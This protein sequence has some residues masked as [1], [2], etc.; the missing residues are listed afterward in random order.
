MTRS[1]TTATP[2]LSGSPEPAGGVSCPACGWLLYRKRLDRTPPLCPE[3]DHPPRLSA[4]ARLDLLVD[5]DTFTETTFPPGPP[6]PLSFADL[7]DYPDRL[8]EPAR[9]SGE[10]EAV[11]V[12]VARLGGVE[13]VF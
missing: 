8:R 9:R 11:V 13:V 4:P 6:D 3:C 10:S 7:R 1:S 5:T 12:G 2:G